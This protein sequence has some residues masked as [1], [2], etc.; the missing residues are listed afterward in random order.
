MET[1]KLYNHECSYKHCK[2]KFK[3]TSDKDGQCCSENCYM[4]SRLPREDGKS[5]INGRW[6]KNGRKKGL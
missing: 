2:A 4:D 1:L 5:F 3:T 6:R